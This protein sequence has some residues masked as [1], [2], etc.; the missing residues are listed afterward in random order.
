MLLQICTIFKIFRFYRLRVGH[1]L[2]F[3]SSTRLYV[4]VGPSDDEEEESEK[5]VTELLKERLQKDFE[6]KKLAER[7]ANDPTGSIFKVVEEG[8]SWGMGKYTYSYICIFISNY[9]I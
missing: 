9:F 8:I 7:R 5:S 6:R 2:K 1:V 4:V 3:G